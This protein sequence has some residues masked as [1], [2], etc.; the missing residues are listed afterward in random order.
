M[1]VETAEEGDRNVESAPAPYCSGECHWTGNGDRRRS[2]LRIRKFGCYH[3]GIGGRFGS[4]GRG[5]VTLTLS[6]PRMMVEKEIALTMVVQ[7]NAHHAKEAYV[8]LARV[9]TADDLGIALVQ[10]QGETHGT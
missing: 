2:G 3:H 4:G 10:E 6:E 9:F 1:E 5:E 7:L 8:A